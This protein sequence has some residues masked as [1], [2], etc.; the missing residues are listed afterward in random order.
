[1]KMDLLN[2]VPEVLPAYEYCLS[3]GMN[4]EEAAYIF[5]DPIVKVAVDMSRGD[6]FNRITPIDR[7]IRVFNQRNRKK[8][9]EMFKARGYSDSEFDAKCNVLFQI[10]EGANELTSLGRSLGINGGISVEVG[11]P[12]SFELNIERLVNDSIKDKIDPAQ[13]SERGL[14][15]NFEMF[16]TN[17]EYAK[18]W[19]DLFEKYKVR[20]N[21]L[22]LINS[23]PHFKA[24]FTVPVQF[25]HIVQLL[26]KSVDTTYRLI[27]SKL[28]G[29][30]IID[31]DTIR[32]VLNIV[33]DRMIYDF[34]REVPF[35]FNTTWHYE[36]ADNSN[37][38]DKVEHDNQGE[39][40]MSTDS[41][42]GIITLKKWIEERVIG[43][44]MSNSKYANNA[45]VDNLIR[46]NAPDKYFKS[47]IPVFGSRIRLN[48]INNEDQLA[49]IKNDF[50]QIQND[51][52]AGH[53]VFEWMFMY[54]LLVNKHRI[55]HNSLALLFD[56]GTDLSDA[57]NIA[58]RWV[59]F[60][61]RYDQA[62]ATY[63]TMREL[64][65][66]PDLK[67]VF[68]KKSYDDDMEF[69]DYGDDEV[70]RAPRPA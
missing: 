67:M 7:I 16:V 54:D 70:R 3:L 26:S 57:D 38:V 41:K 58:A 14:H 15:F 27:E 68:K 50:Y 46:N 35:K 33:N 39:M 22:D 13:K 34:L 56:Q 43:E 45:F 28:S 59:N 19:I 17:E 51:V 63:S 61:N 62:A 23:V 37:H 21:I 66:I 44:L 25:K 12:L 20:F 48:D 55:T 10:F 65:K 9:K 31:E 47:L 64:Q 49:I 8:L 32:S 24:M 40:E 53:T 29:Q 1:M 6:L 5:T 11:E 42:E 4:L 30:Y 60:V 52:I 2:A 69:D 18:R 36:I